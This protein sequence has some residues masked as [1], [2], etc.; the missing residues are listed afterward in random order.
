MDK[1]ED[2][3]VSDIAVGDFM[4]VSSPIRYIENQG[5]V[6]GY[7]SCPIDSENAKIIY[8]ENGLFGIVLET[9]RMNEYVKVFLSYGKTVWFYRTNLTRFK[10]LTSHENHEDQTSLTLSTSIVK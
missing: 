10:S 8:V 5:L 2:V 3:C 7:E 4:F 9:R 6:I 1:L